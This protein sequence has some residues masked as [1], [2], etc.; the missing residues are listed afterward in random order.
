MPRDEALEEEYS[1]PIGTS[2]QPHSSLGASDGSYYDPDPIGWN[3][4][5]N[6]TPPPEEEY[7]PPMGF[8]Q[9]QHSD[10]QMEASSTADATDGSRYDADVVGWNRGLDP[11]PRQH[12]VATPSSQETGKVK[13]K[14]KHCQAPPMPS[15]PYRR[16]GVYTAVNAWDTELKSCMHELQVGDHVVSRQTYSRSSSKHP[17]GRSD[18]GDRVEAWE[19]GT[20]ES[21]SVAAAA[22]VFR[23]WNP[24]A[25]KSSYVFVTTDKQQL[26]YLQGQQLV[27][28][29][30]FRDA[31]PSTIQ[32]RCVVRTEPNPQSVF[33]PR[34]PRLVVA[35]EPETVAPRGP[36][37]TP[38]HDTLGDMS[39]DI[40]EPAYGGVRPLPQR[41]GALRRLPA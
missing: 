9:H 3:W 37:T 7:S 30:S 5:L 2:Q 33:A 34:K 20:V 26:V 14:G 4:R 8:S 35:T 16:T 24:I 22:Q 25:E 38:E 1:P 12:T 36:N 23:G 18:C 31:A 13:G 19:L 28:R 39:F 10:T 40:G 17:Y 21:S 15:S 41:R 6:P 27:F 29:S 11:T 32:P